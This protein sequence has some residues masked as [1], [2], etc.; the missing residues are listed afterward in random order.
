M[1]VCCTQK[2]IYIQFID[3][4]T[5]KTLVSASTLDKEAGGKDG[6]KSNMEGA[7]KVAELAAKRAKQAKISKAVFDR[8]GFR[9]HGRVKA[10]ADTARQAGL[11][12]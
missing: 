3:D 5:G 8:G 10:I 1:S 6:L 11:Q 2:H 4:S 12:I 7:V 9:F